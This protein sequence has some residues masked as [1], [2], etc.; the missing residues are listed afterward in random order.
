MMTLRLALVG[1]LHGI[2]LKKII[3]FIGFNEA[4]SRFGRLR[5]ALD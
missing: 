3:S 4:S 2:D 1:G 5:K